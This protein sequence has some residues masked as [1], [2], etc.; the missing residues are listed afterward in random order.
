MKQLQLIEIAPANSSPRCLSGCSMCCYDPH[1]HGRWVQLQPC[2]H[3][4]PEKMV[5]VDENGDAWMK[6]RPNGACVA[7]K[8]GCCS[9]YTR[10]PL[11]CRQY[12]AQTDCAALIRR[13]RG[14]ETMRGAPSDE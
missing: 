13:H 6:H 11:T 2:D 12:E 4:I 10:R 7:L 1:G 14:G 9:I 3:Q 5:S 8:D